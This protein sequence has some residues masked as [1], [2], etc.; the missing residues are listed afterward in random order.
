MFELPLQVLPVSQIV[1]RGTQWLVDTFSGFFDFITV[2]GTR[3]LEPLA[4]EAQAWLFVY[5]KRVALVSEYI[6]AFGRG[7]VRTI[8]WAGPQAD[9]HDYKGCF[10]GWNVET[11]NADE[12][13]G[14]AW[15]LIATAKKVPE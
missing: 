8:V 1:E 5:P 2:Y 6:A 4:A 12:V 15:E 3:F 10:T 14:K 7:N 13:G 9:W 11:T